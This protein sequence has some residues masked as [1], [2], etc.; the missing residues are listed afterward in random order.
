MKKIILL[1]LLLTA[2]KTPTVIEERIVEVNKPVTVPCVVGER[3]EEVS[4]LNKQFTK[5]QW[6]ALTTDQREKLIAANAMAR[7]A[8]GD[9]VFSITVGCP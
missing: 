1:P 8:Y 3:P 9:L 2:C 6:D 4:P 7:K 5:E